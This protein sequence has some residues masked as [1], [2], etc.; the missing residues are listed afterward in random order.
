MAYTLRFASRLTA[1][2]VQ[3]F[4]SLEMALEAAEASGP[5]YYVAYRHGVVLVVVLAIYSMSEGDLGAALLFLFGIDLETVSAKVASEALGLGFF[6]IGVGFSRQAFPRRRRRQVARVGR[7]DRARH[8]E[9]GQRPI[10]YGRRTP[11]RCGH[12][13]ARFW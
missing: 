4:G 13:I 8:R 1:A 7:V 9:I 6:S 5:D 10:N 11:A 2:T 12:L 3:T